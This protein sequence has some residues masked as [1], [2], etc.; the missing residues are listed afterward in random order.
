MTQTTAYDIAS[1]FLKALG[2]PDT[3]EMRRAVTVW[4]TFESSKTVI[5]NNPWNL[6]V[7]Q[8]CSDPSGYCPIQGSSMPGLVGNRYAGTGDKNVA[9][10]DTIT[11]GTKAA[12]NN[13]VSLSPSYGYGTVIKEAR[14]GNAVGFLTALQNSGWSAGHYGHSKLVTNYNAGGGKN[15]SVNLTTP[16]KNS[17]TSGNTTPTPTATQADFNLNPLDAASGAINNLTTGIQETAIWFSFFVLGALLLLGGIFLLAKG[18]AEKGI[19][20]IGPIAAAAA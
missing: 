13:L 5:G 15:F 9:V 19:Q 16:A 14:S 1:S 12:A 10:F 4:L 6:H 8:A 11:S 18:P 17:G 3:P 2:A 7:G 20:T